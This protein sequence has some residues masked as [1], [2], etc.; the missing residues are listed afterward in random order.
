MEKRLRRLI[1]VLLILDGLLVVLLGR[2]FVKLFRFVP[3]GSAYRRFMTWWSRRPDWLLRASGLVQATAGV[4]VM[5]SAPLSTSELYRTVAGA[6]AKDETAWRDRLYPEAHATFDR[7]MRQ[8]LPPD[9]DVL[10]LGCGTAPSLTRLRALSAPFG[11]YTGVDISADMLRH[12]W[13]KAR[14]GR[15]IYFEQLDLETAPLPEGPFDL[16][17]S[18]WTL[19]HLKYPTALVQKAYQHLRPGAHMLLLFQIDTGFWWGRIVDR[20]LRFLSLRQVPEA[21]YFDFPGLHRIRTFRG[22]LGDLALIV[23]RKPYTL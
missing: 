13:V 1:G 10:D 15:N 4:A 16:I 7:L 3:R 18:T 23:L 19:E 5:S 20:M 17:I 6:Y 12:A 22:P 14:A 21:I 9:G 11:T 8:L 2:P